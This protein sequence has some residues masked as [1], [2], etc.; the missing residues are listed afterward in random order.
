[1]VGASITLE[2]PQKKAVIFSPLIDL[3]VLGGVSVLFYAIFQAIDASTPFFMPDA[4]GL[5]VIFVLSLLV[6]QPHYSA[7]YYR[8]YRSWEQTKRYSVVSIWIPIVLVLISIWCFLAPSTVAGW[9]CK[10]Y[11]ATVSYH[12]AGQTYGVA[13]IFTHKAGIQVDRL[14]KI[15][16]GVPIYTSAVLWLIGD[17]TVS[18]RRMFSSVA[19]PTFGFPNWTYVIALFVLI[20]GIGLY[21]AMSVY[22]ARTERKLPLIVHIV[23]LSQLLWFTMAPRL[24][25]FAL[26]VPFFHCLQYLLIT[27]YFYFQ[28]LVKSKKIA[29]VSAMDFFKTLYFWRY[30]AVLIV[31]GLIIFNAIPFLL[32]YFKLSSSDFAYA[33]VYSFVNL[34]HFL[35]D[36]EIWKLRKPD[37]GKALI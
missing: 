21:I 8:V 23:V 9:F 35:L 11:F 19:L 15:C 33:I 24:E 20:V 13:L 31:V 3:F 25:Y 2:Q 7:T 5:Q 37:I 26:Y 4:N 1:M 10:I 16:M 28:E 17:E 29:T 14:L 12:Y 30:Y 22:V 32:S 34:H 36:G 18:N 6:N 27:T